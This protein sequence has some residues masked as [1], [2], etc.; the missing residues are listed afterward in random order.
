MSHVET[1]SICTALLRSRPMSCCWQRFVASPW[2]CL[3]GF[4]SWAYRRSGDPDTP[5]FDSLHWV[6]DSTET[7]SSPNVVKSVGIC[8]DE[9]D[10]NRSPNCELCGSEIWPITAHHVYCKSPELSDSHNSNQRFW[11]CSHKYRRNSWQLVVEPWETTSCS[12]CSQHSIFFFGNE[13]YQSLRFIILW[14]CESVV[15]QASGV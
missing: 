9:K 4:Q 11:E 2:D 6:L 13:Y 10:E 15:T 8:W 3:V 5:G 14:H 12:F 7:W 1:P